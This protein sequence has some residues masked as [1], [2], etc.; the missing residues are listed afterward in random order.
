[1][2][3][4]E[5]WIKRFGFV[6]REDERDELFGEFLEFVLCAWVGGD[7]GCDVGSDTCGVPKMSD[8]IQGCKYEIH[9]PPRAAAPRRS[10]ALFK[11][12][13]SSLSLSRRRCSDS[14]T[15]SSE[16]SSESSSIEAF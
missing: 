16:S 15:D 5:R 7:E 1:M 6:P 10:V 9:P 13:S 12:A 4:D 14:S 3:F 2:M 11:S 8:R